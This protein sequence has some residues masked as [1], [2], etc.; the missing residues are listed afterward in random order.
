MYHTTI[1]QYWTVSVGFHCC[2]LSMP[3]TTTFFLL[4]CVFYSYY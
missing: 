2:S 3:V 4:V 1:F